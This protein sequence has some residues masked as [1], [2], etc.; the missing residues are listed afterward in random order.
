MLSKQGWVLAICNTIIFIVVLIGM[1]SVKKDAEAGDKT[2]ALIKNVVALVFFFIIMVLQVYSLNCMITG[3]C[4]IWAWIL[5]IFAVLTT[6]LYM[7]AF[8]MII[9]AANKKTQAS[10]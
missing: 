6:V 8:V 4:H 5:A 10:S 1:F 7:I 3:D 2:K 9:F